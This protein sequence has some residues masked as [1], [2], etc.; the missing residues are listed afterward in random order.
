MIINGLPL[1]CILSFSILTHNIS[2]AA[3]N[4]KAIQ[5]AD[6]QAIM[7]TLGDET[8]GVVNSN[9][10]QDVVVRSFINIIDR[11]FVAHNITKFV[12]GTSYRKMNEQQRNIATNCLKVMMAM[13]YSA[14][15][16]DFKGAS[17]KIV[18][19]K[20]SSD[21]HS[22]VNAKLT[23]KNAEYDLSCSIFLSDGSWKIFDV[24]VDGTSM[25]KIM[26]AGLE[27]R[28]NK[29]GLDSFL[30]SFEKKYGDFNGAAKKK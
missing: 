29:E 1:I 4:G 21:K 3:K 12:F 22:F 6:A 23:T 20:K 24:I 28:I 25:S 16:A 19:V 18:N 5:N 7:Q 26:R 15:F 17:F 30:A 27:G 8:L 13:Q 9:L 14:K 2:V 11:F 10:T